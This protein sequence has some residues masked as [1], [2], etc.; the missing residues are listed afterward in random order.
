ML[1]AVGVTSLIHVHPM[2]D[3]GV[4]VD[5][6]QVTYPAPQRHASDDEAVQIMV[7][8]D[9]KIVFGSALVQPED[10]TAL[11]RKSVAAGAERKVY[12]E[13]DANVEYGKVAQVAEAVR[14]AGIQ[15]I[16]FLTEKK[17]PPQLP[18]KGTR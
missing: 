13:A 9:G 17:T 2:I 10:I 4:S 14:A 5:L 11:V 16:V 3:P 8:R 1:A 12:I 7:M 6:P 15:N 18:K